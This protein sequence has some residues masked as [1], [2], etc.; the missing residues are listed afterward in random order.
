MVTPTKVMSLKRH[1]LERGAR[2]ARDKQVSFSQGE[3]SHLVVNLSSRTLTATEV[4]TQRLVPTNRYS[5]FQT[6]ID[7]YW[8]IRQLKNIV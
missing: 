3:E 2:R 8:L 7:L 4:R 1:F 5:T 6:H